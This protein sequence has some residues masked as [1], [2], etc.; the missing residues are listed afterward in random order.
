[1]IIR[2]FAVFALLAAAAAGTALA[3]TPAPFGTQPPVPTKVRV[4]YNCNNLKLLATY[5]NKKSQVAF[6]YAGKHLV[7][8][9]APS[10]DGARF[11]NSQLEWWAKG[12]DATLS[13]VTNGQ[14]DTVLAKCVAQK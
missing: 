8:K 14:A 4:H 9:R 10:A 6:I 12:N 2:S 5:D 1:V 3:Q 7:L 11:A 13:S